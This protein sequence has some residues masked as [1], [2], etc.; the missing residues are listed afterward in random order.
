MTLQDGQRLV[1]LRNQALHCFRRDRLPVARRRSCLREGPLGLFERTPKPF[2]LAAES[3]VC[4]IER[5]GLRPPL[6]LA[7]AELVERRGIEAVRIWSVKAAG[8]DLLEQV[9]R[10]RTLQ[11][12][13][14]DNIEHAVRHARLDGRR[15]AVHRHPRRIRKSEPRREACEEPGR[16]RVR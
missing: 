9:L 1:L 2:G 4:T 13:P 5:R 12:A 11:G 6:Q 3:F 10:R 14:R 8:I 7:A 16:R 15:L